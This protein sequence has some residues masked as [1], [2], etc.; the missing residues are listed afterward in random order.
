MQYLLTG[1][2]TGLALVAVW[3]GLF[4]RSEARA[5]SRTAKRLDTMRGRFIALEAAFDSLEASHRKLTGQFHAA[6]RELIAAD[7][8]REFQEEA[9]GPLPDV[10]VCDN[11]KLAQLQGPMSEAASCECDY[12]LRKRSERAAIR[13]E[14][15]KTFPKHADMVN[16]IKAKS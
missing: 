9:R 16:A 6:K 15:R 14:L 1:L 5:V 13:A 8:E 10:T 3:W 12:C 11:Y 4:A 2:Y 7:E